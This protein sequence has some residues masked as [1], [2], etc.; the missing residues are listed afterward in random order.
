MNPKTGSIA[1]YKDGKL[2]VKLEKDTVWLSQAQIA[3]LFQTERS[4]VTKHLINI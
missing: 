4:D 2:E 1:I 3:G